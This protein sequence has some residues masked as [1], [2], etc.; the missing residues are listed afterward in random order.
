M[1]KLNERSYRFVINGN[2]VH[3]TADEWRLHRWTY[4]LSRS[5][6][7]GGG[8]A[9]CRVSSNYNEFLLGLGGNGSQRLFPPVFENEGNCLPEI[10]KTF[11]S[12]RALPIRTRNL[13][14]VGNVPRTVLLHDRCKLVAHNTH[15]LPP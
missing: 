5:R 3:W 7:V 9:R 2:P 14:A 15:S 11:V 4:C 8:G 6:G 12:R 13:S 1:V 10:R